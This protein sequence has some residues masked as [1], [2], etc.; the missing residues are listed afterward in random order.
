VTGSRD[1]RIPV[2]QIGEFGLIDRITEV[3][4]HMPA[5]EVGPGDD[6]AVLAVSGGRVVAGMDLL[7]E[8]IHFRRD[9]SSGVDVGVKAAAQ[10]LADIVAMGAVPTAL[11]VGLAIPA[12]LPASWPLDVAEGL[13]IECAR[14]GVSVVG[15]DLTRSD[16]I[17]IAVS[18]LGELGAGRA[19]RRSGARSGDVVAVSSIPGSSA[20]GLAVLQRGFTAPRGAVAAHRRPQPDYEAGLRAAK[21]ASALI[22]ISDGLLADAGHIAR[23]S[24]VTL[25]ISRSSVVLP[26]VVAQVASALHA[27]PWSWVLAGGEDHVFLGTF[28]PD[29]IPEGFTTLGSVVAAGDAPVLLDGAVWSGPSGHDHFRPEN[30]PA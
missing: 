1:P 29:G 23:A 8:G 4:A 7:I 11:L 20:A 13:R 5:V 18:A 30:S 12:D 22:D 28:A 19:I 17:C 3:F 27:D 25:T 10:N 15:G 26:E 2:G 21:S 24:G 16:R 14:L 6:A 9:W